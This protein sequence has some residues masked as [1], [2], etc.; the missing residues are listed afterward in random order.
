MNTLDTLLVF[1]NLGNFLYLPVHTIYD[2]KWKDLGKH[3]SN[4]VPL[5]QEEEIIGAIPV[6]DFNQNINIII[7]T[8]NGMIKRTPLKDFKIT[9]ISKP[10]TCMKLKSD[11]KVV[12]VMLDLEEEI[13]IETYLG[14][15]LW[16]LKEEIPI[17]GIKASGV[18]AINLKGDNVVSISNFADSDTNYLA[19]LT[20]KGTGKRVKLTEFE[21][22]TRARRGLMTIRDVKT[23]PYHIIKAFIVTNKDHIGL[24]NGEVN[25]IKSTELPIADRYSTGSTV[26]KKGLTEA[27][28][29]KTLETPNEGEKEIEK[30][31]ITLADIDKRL[32]TIDDFLK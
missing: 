1:T 28:L 30:E 23:N 6:K 18:K 5:D 22:T 13:F 20:D 4:L 24:K 32:M 29:Y 19:V 14:Y 7:G 16:F 25:I 11:D 3:V 8:K 26:N 9:R 21:R 17:V 27:F 15:G 31:K 12:S 2:L 10:S